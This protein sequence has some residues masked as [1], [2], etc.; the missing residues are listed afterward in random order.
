MTK[1]DYNRLARV[2][3][4]SILTINPAKTYSLEWLYYELLKRLIRE[5]Q[6]D[7]PKFDADRFMQSLE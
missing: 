5:L 7:N 6:I 2:F 4:R 3:K 1:K